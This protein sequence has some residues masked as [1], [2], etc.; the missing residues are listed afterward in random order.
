[1]VELNGQPL[2]EHTLAR[3]ESQ[4]ELIIISSSDPQLA[5]YQR[6]L[7]NDQQQDRLGPLAGIYATM[8]WLQHHQPQIQWLQ[9]CP[10]D[11]PRLPANLFSQLAQA[12][13]QR[14]LALAQ[15]PSADGLRSQPLHSLWS[16]NLAPQL[17]KHLAA[18]QYRVMQFIRQQNAV[19]VEFAQAQE[20]QNINTPEDLKLFQLPTQ[21]TYIDNYAPSY[22]K[23]NEY[24]RAMKLTDPQGREITYLRLS[25]T[26]RCDFR[27]VYCMAEEM[28]FLPRAQVLS[29]EEINIIARAF[30][31]LGI[32]TIRLTGGEPLVR[33]DAHTLV[34]QLKQIPGLRQLAMTSNGSQLPRYAEQLHRDGLDRIN[35]SLDTL[36]PERFRSLS[37]TG[38]LNTVLEG[39][40][41]ARKAGFKHLKLNSVILKN[42]NLD[43]VADL[44]EFALTRDLDI[45]FIEAMPLGQIDDHDRGQEFISSE[46][47]HRILSQHWD[48][49]TSDYKTG[50][51]SRYWEI[52][53]YSSKI[54]F[55]SPHTD[56]FCSS[57]NRVR[58]TAEG[59][60]LL[61]LG[62]E[63]AIDL[64]AIIRRHPGESE[65]LKAAIID[66]IG[67]KPDRHHFDLNDT[68]IVRFMN[69][70]GG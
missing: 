52:A 50:G 65:R 44:A 5:R 68:Q 29:L 15:S 58:V 48:L 61:C 20:F 33:K 21:I 7:V 17:A 66:A 9:V 59:K 13:N 64:K 6:P 16:I 55:I 22:S 41:A 27:C 32:D 70:T 43:E 45:S 39:I 38:D 40:E 34:K 14:Q 10:V 51:P 12:A 62:N 54:G 60:L 37:R 24:T 31:E 57:C 4:L 42:R 69:T 56:N 19:L 63:N 47:I 36:Q 46:G 35:I 28:T 67:H 1:M 3:L 30:V 26:D 23:H 8:L 11:T 53:G 2:I 18:Q 25:V 49:K